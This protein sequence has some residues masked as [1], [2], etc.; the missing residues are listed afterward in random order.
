MCPIVRPGFSCVAQTTTLEEV[1]TLILRV[2]WNPPVQWLRGLVPCSGTTPRCGS[3]G[4][5]MEADA[6]FG[7]QMPVADVR[8]PGGPPSG[9]RLPGRK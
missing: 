1:S 5:H 7:P 2:F 3:H 9:G 8:G 4:E 6:V